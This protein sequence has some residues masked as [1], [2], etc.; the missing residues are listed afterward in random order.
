MPKM[1][2][3]TAEDR[4]AAARPGGSGGAGTRAFRFAAR[5]QNRVT[6][7]FTQRMVLARATTG[8]L[9]CM[10]TI[11]T[12]TAGYAQPMSTINTAPA[13]AN[14]TI[15]TVASRIAGRQY[16]IQIFRPL[17]PPPPEGYAVIFITDGSGMF[18]TAADQMWAREYS[19]LRPALIIG[20]SQPTDEIS[21]F[22]RLRTWDFTPERPNDSFMPTFRSFSAL[23]P[24]TA[25][26]TG[27]T[28]L[29]YRFITE[30]LRPELAKSYHID[31]KNQALFGHSLGGLFTLHVLFNHPTAFSTYVVS[32][33]S[34]VWNGGSVLKAEAAFSSA[35]SKGSIAPRILFEKGS[36]EPGAEVLA[37]AD[38]LKALKGATRYE[39]S[40]HDFDGENHNSVTAAAVSRA[41]TFAFGKVLSKA[42]PLTTPVID[43]AKNGRVDGTKRE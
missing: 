10:Y 2:V 25:N 42:T 26:D 29:F 22:I 5:L 21:E 28:E 15:I 16:R 11:V 39:V 14:E 33:P 24:L 36:L 32:S 37:L 13:A 9:L 12:A 7:R 34:I 8:M 27:G 6:Q 19:D 23:S 20:I 43:A 30:E 17:L 1:I 38:R 4:V 3:R 18:R 35:V 40:F 31:I 41:L